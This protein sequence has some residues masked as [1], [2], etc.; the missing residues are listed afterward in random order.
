MQYNKFRGEVY[1]RFPNASAF[2][3]ALGWAKQKASSIINGK[4]VPKLSD[5]QDMAKVMGMRVDEVASFF[6]PAPSQKCDKEIR[7]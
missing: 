2:A 6:L 1:S 7:Q 4:S 3:R 5:I